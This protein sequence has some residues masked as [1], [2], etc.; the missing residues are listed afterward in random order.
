MLKINSIGHVGHAG[1]PFGLER[2]IQLTD[3]CNFRFCFDK[4]YLRYRSH[5]H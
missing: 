3:T 4:V 5:N 2:I 1:H